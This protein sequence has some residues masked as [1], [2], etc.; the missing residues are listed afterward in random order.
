MREKPG[1]SSPGEGAVTRNAGGGH[2]VPGRAA[3]GMFGPGARGPDP[4]HLMGMLLRES[5][6]AAR[7]HPSGK[8]GKPRVAGI[9]SVGRFDRTV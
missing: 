7:S 5:S 4:C 3:P 9:V 6:E 8:G 2:P 1:A